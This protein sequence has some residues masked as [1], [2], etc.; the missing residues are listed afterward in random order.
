MKFF[1]FTVCFLAISMVTL[2]SFTATH[3]I[4]T[5][6]TWNLE[7]LA[8]NNDSGCKP[9]K[10]S[11]YK[12][13]KTYAVALQADIV[14]FQEVENSAAAYRIF[15][16]AAYQIEISAR[17]EIDLGRCRGNERDRL[18]QRTGF[19]VR[20]DL[21][22]KHGISYKRLA[23]VQ[24]LAVDPSERWGVQI[25]LEFGDAVKNPLHLLCV[26]LK[27]GCPH[28]DLSDQDDDSPCGKL[29]EQ[30]TRLEAW[31]DARAEAGEQFIVLGDMN[32]QLDALGDPVWEALDDSEICSWERP[33]SG[34]WYCRNGTSRFSPIADLERARAGRKHPYPLNPRYPFAIDHI[35]MSAGA[36][37]MAIEKTA[38]FIRCAPNL[39][40][41]AALV[42]K[43]DFKGPR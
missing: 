6:C 41:H 37:Q 34:P 22:E 40:D 5:I 10:D 25:V 27:S 18:M 36:D 38:E 21:R 20:K 3:S 17:P 9:R 23:D 24:T 42:M 39:S 16:P 7:H 29:A 19:A 14:A 1:Y 8:A 43:L 13:L 2:P 26:H 12:A 28:K 32:R 33:V 35:I 11:D 31:L 15:D 30:V 4:I